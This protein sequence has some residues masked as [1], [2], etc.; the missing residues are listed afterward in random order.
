[1]MGDLWVCVCTPVPMH[2]CPACAFLD[3][4]SVCMCVSLCFSCMF[5][6]I[7]MF[8]SVNNE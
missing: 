2:C 3:L 8:L 1:M 4:R 5:G 7:D 6:C